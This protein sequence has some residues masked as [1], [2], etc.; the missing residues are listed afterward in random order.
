MRCFD[1]I[2]GYGLPLRGFAIILTGHITL[3]WTPLD[4]RSDRCRDLYLTTH[5]THTRQTS[6]LPARF[7][8]TIPASERPQT[9]AL[10]HAATG[11]G[12]KYIRLIKTKSNNTRVK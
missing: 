10:D 9:H 8:P 6:M 1:P 4:D 11:I 12:L 7:E 3:G 5:N 2:P